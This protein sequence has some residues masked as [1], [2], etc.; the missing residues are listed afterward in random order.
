MRAQLQEEQV[1][2]STRC[3]EGKHLEDLSGE[4]PSREEV[5]MAYKMEFVR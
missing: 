1:Q 3:G 5:V 4:K 2:Q